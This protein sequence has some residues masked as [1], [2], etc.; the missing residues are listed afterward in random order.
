[1]TG[2]IGAL[3]FAAIVGYY[4]A[5]VAADIFSALATDGGAP[6]ASVEAYSMVLAYGSGLVLFA[7]LLL[8]PIELI[9]ASAEIRR[10]GNTFLGAAAALKRLQSLLVILLCLISVTAISFFLLLVEKVGG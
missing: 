8:I 4:P 2:Q 9:R 10:S 1:M 3:A 7:G 5:I 6:T